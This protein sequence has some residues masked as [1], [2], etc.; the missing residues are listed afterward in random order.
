SAFDTPWFNTQGND[1][2]NSLNKTKIPHVILTS[3]TEDFDEETIQQWRD[4]GFDTA[5]VPMLN[6]GNEYIN[7][8]HTQGD[9]FG[10]GE[11]YAIVAFDSAAT[12]ILQA[13]QKPNHPKLVAIVAYYPPIIP[14]VNTKYP[15]GIR[16]LVHLAGTEVGG[17]RQTAV[18]GIQGKVKTTQKRLSPG[19]G[20]GE[21]L[22]L[23]YP[24]YTYAGIQPGF[25]ERDLD[26][27][28]PVAERL[29]FTRSLTTL[30]R[31]FRIEPTTIEVLRDD[32]VDYEA[33]GRADKAL[34]HI[35]PYAHVINGPTLTG[36][37]GTKDLD[38]Y[39]RSFFQPLPPSFRARLLS[40]TMGTD[41]ICDEI[42]TSFTHS[43][44]IPWLLPGIPATGKKVEVVMVSI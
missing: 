14:S 39:Y 12:L 18:L 9:N 41:H 8:V 37:V 32:L 33:S 1:F 10:V 24:A 20:Y 21:P 23:S 5:Y 31:A 15:P 7:R 3:E 16:V 42:F 34:A 22:A 6:G 38:T 26:E 25:A 19:P 11:Y 36:G 13:H 28:D 43:Q 40:R 17:Q 30:R 29:A 27:Y 4:E 44:E 35:R 2:F